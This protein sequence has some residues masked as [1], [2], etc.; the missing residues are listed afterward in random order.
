MCATFFLS[1]VLLFFIPT[2]GISVC[3]PLTLTLALLTLCSNLQCTTPTSWS[4][5]A[6]YAFKL[7]SLGLG[8]W[9]FCPFCPFV[10]FLFGFL[11]FHFCSLVVRGVLCFLIMQ[12]GLGWVSRSAQCSGLAPPGEGGSSAAREIRAGS[13]GG[14]YWESS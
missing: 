2:H 13:W 9:V 10:F 4:S 14:E 3:F 11:S 7:C 12:L 8:G 6:C 1:F 5:A